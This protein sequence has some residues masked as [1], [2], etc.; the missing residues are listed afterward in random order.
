MVEEAQGHTAVTRV[1][2]RVTRSH[3]KNLALAYIW[4]KMLCTFTQLYFL[5]FFKIQ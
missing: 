5:V 3:R 2:G 4:T 1:T